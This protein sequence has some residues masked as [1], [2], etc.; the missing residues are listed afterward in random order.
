MKTL[1]LITEIEEFDS[2]D[3][4]PEKDKELLLEAR[5]AASKAYAPYSNFKVGAAIRMG[6]GKIVQGSNQENSSYPVGCC[7]ERTALFY[8]SSCFWGEKICAI[9]IASQTTNSDGTRPLSPCGMCRQAILEYE[10]LQQAPI[11]I[12]MLSGSTKVWIAPSAVSLL[13]FQFD[14]Q[15]LEQ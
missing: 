13:P 10:I 9:A 4:L 7:A 2:V 15:Y 1:T 11:R 6:N 8:A 12:L 14:H 5:E 3:Q